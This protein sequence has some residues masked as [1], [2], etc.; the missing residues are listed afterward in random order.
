MNMNRRESLGLLLGTACSAVAAEPW[1]VDVTQETMAPWGKTPD[2]LEPA[3]IQV[4]QF[5]YLAQF[6]SFPSFT[7]GQYLALVKG[8]QKGEY[9]LRAAKAGGRDTKEPPKKTHAILVPEDLARTIYELWSNMLFET[10]YPKAAYHGL[11]GTT[12]VFSTFIRALGWMHGSVWSPDEDQPPGWITKLAGE[13][14][15][16]ATQGSTNEAEITKRVTATR[17]RYFAH[18]KKHG[19]H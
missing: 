6:V 4:P 12:Y 10:R 7:E 9:E 18:L 16:F 11:D 13:L 8:K 3:K 14:H 5:Y 1:K 17:E 2:H 15:Q 19:R